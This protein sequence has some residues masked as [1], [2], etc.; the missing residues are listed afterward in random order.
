MDVGWGASIL[1]VVPSFFAIAHFHLR[2]TFFPL[3]LLYSSDK[4]TGYG[5]HGFSHQ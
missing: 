3:F 2:K 5:F 4:Y 1:F